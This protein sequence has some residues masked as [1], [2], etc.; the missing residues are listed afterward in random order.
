MRDAERESLKI[1]AVLGA[2]NIL[3]GMI[4][5]ILFSM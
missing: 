1:I 4:F 2:T 3:I 5:G